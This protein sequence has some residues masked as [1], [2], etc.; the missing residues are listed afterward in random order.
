MFKVLTN[1]IT[2]LLDLS[3]CICMRMAENVPE[4]LQLGAVTNEKLDEAVGVKSGTK[5]TKPQ[6]SYTD[7]DRFKIADYATKHGATNAAV[8]FQD[9]YQTLGESTVRFFVK[10]YKE[11]K[12]ENRNDATLP[13]LQRGRPLLLGPSIDAQIQKYILVLYQKGG[14][15]SRST[16]V[17]TS[18]VL[19][20]QSIDR[21][22]KGIIVSEA[23]PKSLLR[24]MGFRRRAATTGKIEIPDCAKRES[25]L[26]FHYKVTKLADDYEIPHCLIMNSDQT[27]SKYVTTGRTTFA[28]KNSQHVA[29][30]GANDKRAITL[31]RTVTV[32]GKMLPFQAIYSGKTK[33]HYP[34]QSF[35][36]GSVSVSTRNIIATLRKS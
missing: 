35:R 32:D 36:R 22:L 6:C 33:N 30:A 1:D 3:D 29:L 7:E 16:A 15:V 4:N 31:T 18:T 2:G 12:S 34:K 9:K 20:E 13:A 24:R 19:L 26:Q 28:P 8:H 5:C 10:K 21:S 27:P 17:I 14:H 25:G 23:W 11:L